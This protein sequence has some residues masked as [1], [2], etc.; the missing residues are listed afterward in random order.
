MN[1]KLKL[2]VLAVVVLA[3]SA[4]C[5]SA[6]VIKTGPNYEVTGYTTHPE[7]AI[8]AASDA[9]VNELNSEECW[10]AVREG[11]IWTCYGGAGMGTDYGFYYGGM[12]PAFYPESP[13]PAGGSVQSG[14]GVT[15]EEL[16]KVEEKADDSL[17]M[18]KKLRDKLQGK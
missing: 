17:R 18:H 10:K 3:L 12:T 5:N 11:R 16:K 8:Q 14:E 4:A 6:H 7:Y 1:R 2:F 15:K 13:S 9:Y